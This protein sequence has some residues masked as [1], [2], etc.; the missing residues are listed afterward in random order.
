MTENSDKSRL[1]NET[2]YVEN[3]KT[4]AEQRQIRGVSPRLGSGIQK[5][6]AD[7]W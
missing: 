4:I 2:F 3:C 7:P 1:F 6:L 5:S